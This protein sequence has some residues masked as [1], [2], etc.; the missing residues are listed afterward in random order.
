[1]E[2]FSTLVWLGIAIIWFL[3]R[4]VRRGVKK[5]VG[6]PQKRPRPAASQQA[7][8]PA[9]QASRPASQSTAAPTE[10]LRGRFRG[11]QD[12]SG[13]GGTGPPPIVPR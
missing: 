1:M 6:P 8:G 13:R 2:D 5:A 10:P 4:I 11:R 3:T 12:F 9:Q 7:S